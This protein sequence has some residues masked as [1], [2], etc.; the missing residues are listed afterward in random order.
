MIKPSFW[1]RF[2]KWIGIITEMS[3]DKSEMCERACII[4]NEDCAT[5]AWA[6]DDIC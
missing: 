2:L 5:C 1:Y 4:C 6:H 3:V